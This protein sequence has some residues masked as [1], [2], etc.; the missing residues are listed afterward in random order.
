VLLVVN[1]GVG[2][3]QPWDETPWSPQ[4]PAPLTVA[5]L[6]AD[7]GADLIGS[8][9][10]GATE[11]KVTS[12][13]TTDY[14]YD[15]VHHWSGAVPAEPVWREEPKDLGKV[16]VSF[17]NY[18]PGKAM[19]FRSDVWRGWAVGNQL[20]APA[21]GERTDWVTSGA[22][23]LDDAFIQ[24]ET[25]QHSVDVL[26]YPAGRTGRVSWFG[27]IQRPRMGPLGYQPVRYLDTMYITAPGWGD[28]GAGHVGEA[29]AN[30]DVKDWMSLYQGD[31]QLDWG[32]AEWLQ[33]PS[34]SPERLP[35]RL[36]VDNDRGT[37]GDPYSTHTLTEWNFTSATTGT[38]SAESLPLIQLDYGVDTDTA[39]RA[40]RRAELTVTASHL[41]GT[42]AAIAKPSLEVSYDDGRTWHPSGLSRTGGAWRTHLSAPRAADFVTLRVTARD[43]AGNSVSQT[44]TR[45]FGLR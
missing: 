38:E 6:N 12:H 35:Y 4:S 33:V 36:V 2:R 37:W 40:G 7:Q 29:G 45:A 31:R 11:L 34:L 3:L 44:I 8:L 15:V 18:R 1:K 17:R 19:E 25:G 24:G 30:F 32:N 5:T 27:P 43:D 26:H 10:H 9:R 23:W 41:P 22:T 28:S 21:Q 39:G 13:P 14:L 20:T 16:D 42:T